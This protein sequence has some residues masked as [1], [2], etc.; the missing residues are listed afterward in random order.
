ME[1]QFNPELHTNTQ[2]CEICGQNRTFV[3]SCKT[4]DTFWKECNNC[5]IKQDIKEQ[6]EEKEIKKTNKKKNIEFYKGHKSLS[7]YIYNQYKR[8][9]EVSPVK[10]AKLGDTLI[11]ESKIWAVKNIAK[12]LG[13]DIK[14]RSE[15]SDWKTRHTPKIR[16][17][18]KMYYLIKITNITARLN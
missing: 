7:E 4:G 12:Q 8:G 5:F 6:K 11:L 16:I 17:G 14:T 13:Y 2:K 15:I 18:R 3:L 10:I 9:V 1:F